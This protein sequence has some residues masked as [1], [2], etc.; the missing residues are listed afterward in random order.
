MFFI[1]SGTVAATPRL[2]SLALAPVGAKVASS[3]EIAEAYILKH[4]TSVPANT[5]QDM[6]AEAGL[7]AQ[8]WSL[9]AF[10]SAFLPNGPGIGWP[11]AQSMITFSTTLEAV[12]AAALVQAATVP[13]NP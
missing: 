9:V 3:W 2:T 13:L 10:E 7:G 4:A 6:K 5:L 12:T 8:T 1:V 11:A